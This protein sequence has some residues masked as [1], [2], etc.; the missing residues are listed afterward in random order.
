[1][2]FKK[3]WG[4]VFGG[5]PP[6]EDTGR[7][8]P[9]ASQGFDV[10]GQGGDGHDSDDTARKLQLEKTHHVSD[11]RQYL[12]EKAAEDYEVTDLDEKLDYAKSFLLR[13]RWCLEIVESRIGM[14]VPKIVSVFLFRIEH[15]EDFEDEWLWV[16]VGD[17]PPGYLV[18]DHA[19]NAAWALVIYIG[20]VREWAEAVRDSVS[21]ADLYPVNVPPTIEWAEQLE[22]RTE[23]LEQEILKDYM[24]DLQLSDAELDEL[25]LDRK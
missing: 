1:M 15:T 20:L 10:K 12:L 22:G 24:D 13:H 21:V 9:Q 8:E 5:G 18:M 14:F 19:P 11:V 25:G 7:V 3:I 2:V 16:V 17:L 4:A 6:S 23:F